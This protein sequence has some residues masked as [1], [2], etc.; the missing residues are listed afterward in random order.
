M[1]KKIVFKT[2]PKTLGEFKEY[3]M[4]EAFETAALTVLALN[5]YATDVEESI[6]ILNELKGPKD[7]SNY[8]ISFFKDRLF[9][10][11]YVVRSYFEGATPENNYEIKSP[12][13]IEVSDN[14]YSYSEDGY[15][16]LL[17]KSNGADSPRPIT[18]RKKDGIWY[19]W[20]QA[21]LADVKAPK[22]L[23]DW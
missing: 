1:E 16:R 20:E 9:N 6:K 2:L 14:E 18:L 13:V 8:D 15:A 7:L 12:Y 4:K 3:E 19:L 23:N 11:E 21:L 17:I 5:V 22:E 10:K